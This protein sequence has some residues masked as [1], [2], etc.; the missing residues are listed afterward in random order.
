MT[1]WETLARAET[2]CGDDIQLRQRGEIFEIRYNGIELM[3]NVSHHSE[4]QLALR[5]LQ[6]MNFTPKR[7]L[8]AGLGLGFTLRAVLNL[9]TDPRDRGVESR[10]AGASG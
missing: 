9:R 6:R 1:V 7:I 8:V 4:D 10:A 3:S 5:L 2:A